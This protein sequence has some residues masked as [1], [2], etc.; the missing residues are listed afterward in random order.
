ML[1]LMGGKVKGGLYGGQPEL[2]K[3]DQNGNLT[4]ATDFRQV[5]ATVIEDWLG[6]NAAKVLGKPVK[7]LE[8]I[9]T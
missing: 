7:K 5:Y 8:L 2:A 1:L 9:S 6:G 4:F 3:L